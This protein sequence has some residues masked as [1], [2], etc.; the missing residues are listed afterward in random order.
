MAR[1]TTN[2]KEC[3]MSL[4][5]L[6]KPK[7]LIPGD[8]VAVISP[9]W[10]GA[11]VYPERYLAGKKQLEDVFGLKVIEAPNALISAEENFYNPKKRVDDLHWA[12]ANTDVKAIVP[13]IGGDDSVRLL[14]YIDFDLIRKNPKI[15]L[16]YSDNTVLHYAFMH[17]GVQSIYGPCMMCGGFAENGGMFDYFKDS[18]HRT[19]FLDSPIGEIKP[20]LKGWTDEE[21]PWKDPKNQSIKRKLKESNG[22][23]FINGHGSVSGRLIGGSLEVMEMLKGSV[24][25][26]S[27][28]AFE[29]AIFFV[30]TC[31]EAPAADYVIRWMR[32]YA[33]TGILQRVKG[34]VIGRPANVS[35]EELD[36]YANA[37]MQVVKT[38]NNLDIPVVSNLDFGHTD[39]MF[40]I[41]YGAIA[42]I[43]TDNKT[44]SILEN[45]VI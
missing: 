2:Q 29:D 26:P 22:F 7:K 31:E 17:A 19:L 35:L 9:S 8:T 36:K 30:E 40:L 15:L 39:P 25:W 33:A 28:D 37:I 1:I 12:L 4:Q 32:N 41:P 5:N 6:I 21:L 44:F 23:K 14:P 3:A 34:I 10:A 18:V 16:G 11:S 13:M 38:E 45:A 43:D 42:K 24:V 27:L 20:N